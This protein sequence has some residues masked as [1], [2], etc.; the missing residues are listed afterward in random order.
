MR[1]ET[2]ST[3]WLNPLAITIGVIAVAFCAYLAA[4]FL[5]AD[6]VRHDD[7]EMEEA[8]RTRALVSG[9]IA[10]HRRRCSD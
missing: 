7:P 6:A 5:A 10:G 8:F 4:V 9:V 3:S 1:R 2:L